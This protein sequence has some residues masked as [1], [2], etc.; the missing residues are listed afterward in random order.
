MRSLFTS[1]FALLMALAAASTATADTFVTPNT[2]SYG[3][4]DGYYPFGGYGYG[5]GYHASTYEE[6]VLAGWGALA[7]SV[8][9]A[10]YFNSLAAINAQEAYSRFLQNRE[11]ATE[12]YFRMQ[13]VNRAARQAERPQRL[14]YEQYVSLAK[15]H[16]PDGLTQG[17]YD[18]TLGRLQWPAIL[19]GEEFAAEREA[20]NH[21]FLVRSPGDVGPTSAFYSNVWRITN[22]MEAKLKDK[23]DQLNSAEY[24]AAKKF[25][26]GLAWESQQPL[27]IPA[28]AAK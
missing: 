15:K 3:D 1:T 28:L 11:R 5:H 7:R 4:S 25:I 14:S 10:N 27:V 22:S 18:R 20:L 16:A 19:Q 24:L 13:Q 2:A 26:T 17:Q 8:G 21:A 12:T 23:I 9:E 6:G